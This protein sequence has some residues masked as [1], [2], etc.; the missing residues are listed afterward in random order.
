MENTTTTATWTFT[1][2]GVSISGT[3]TL[4]CFDCGTLDGEDMYP[5]HTARGYDPLLAKVGLVEPSPFP[6][7]DTCWDDRYFTGP[8]CARGLYA[9]TAGCGCP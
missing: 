4:R 7:C 3:P 5:E 8:G 2:E 1:A 9:H 6:L